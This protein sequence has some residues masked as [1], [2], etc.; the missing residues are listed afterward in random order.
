MSGTLYIVATPIGNLDDFSQRAKDILTQVTL[1]CAEDT[2]QSQRLLQY[3]AIKTPL[4]SL[5]EYN[6]KQRYPQIIEKLQEG[7]DIALISDA[8][9]P[10]IS[11][12][13]YLLVKMCQTQKITVSPIPG[14][15]AFVSALSVAG[16]A[17][18]QFRYF[19]FPPRKNARKKAFLEIVEEPMTLVF[20]E[21]SHRI[22]DC[23]MDMQSVFGAERKVTLC[24]ELTKKYETIYHAN[25]AELNVILAEQNYAQKGEFVIIVA[26]FKVVDDN[27]INTEIENQ[28]KRLMQ[29][30]PL[31]KAAAIL[32]D[33]TGIKKNLLYKKGLSFN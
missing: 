11:D 2:R 27:P 30:L 5:H 22:Q 16:I 25:L 28:L 10:L 20:Y 19:G 1:I 31:K 24:R 33:F 32:A 17:T 14:A 8:G 4:L 7:L 3:Y 23:L 13:G 12:P 9:T 18:D 29:D 21:A 6:E 15:C 26:G